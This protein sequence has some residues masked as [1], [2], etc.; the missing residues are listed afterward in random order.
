MTVIL[1]LACLAIAGAELYMARGSRKVADRLE[2]LEAIALR[3]DERIDSLAPGAE[4]AA[5]GLDERLT[6]TAYRTDAE[7]ARLAGDTTRLRERLK[8]LE[9]ARGVDRKRY[10]RV[11]GAVESLERVVDDLYRH[12][13]SRLDEAVARTLGGVPPGGDADSDTVR[14]VVCGAS[15][16]FQNTLLRAYE[17]CAADAG[18][19]IR[20]QAPGASAPWHARYYLCGK[21]PRE[22]ERDFLALLDS[23]R[24]EAAGPDGAAF[25]RLLLALGDVT[26][27]FVQIGPMVAARG[28]DTLLCG[29]LTLAECRGLDADAMV[30]EP[31][32]VAARLSALP[33]ERVRD[34]TSDLTDWSPPADRELG[35]AQP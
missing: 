28:P 30:G 13:L 18:L 23:V 2:R 21:A 10:A 32:A 19:R 16:P 9:D 11:N 27:G 6:A 12:T 29:V 20:F 22:L 25:R 3:Q 4:D 5:P 7:L 14:G 15:A 34:L 24:S 17:Q 31:A 33:A 35:P 1:I 8:G 26:A